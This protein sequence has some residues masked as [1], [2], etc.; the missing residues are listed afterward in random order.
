MKPYGHSRR[1]RLSCDHG[2]CTEKYGKKKDCRPSTDR[3]RRKTARQEARRL[4]TDLFD[5]N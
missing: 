1:D 3:A 2:C 4:F 5:N